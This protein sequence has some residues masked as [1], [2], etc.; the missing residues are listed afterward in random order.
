MAKEQCDVVVVGA[1]LA[2]LV[3][4]KELL[5]AGRSVQLLEASGDVGGRVR[6]DQVDGFSLDRGFQVLLTAYP[7]LGRQLDL[8]ALDLRNFDPG[9][10]LW[11]NHKL[12]RVGDP[13]RQPS[14]ALSSAIA[15]VGTVPDKLRLARL[16]LRLKRADPKLLLRGEEMTTMQA[17]Q[18][19][20]FS[21]KIIDRFFRPLVGG[22]QLDADLTASRRMFDVVLHC[23]AVGSS[24]VPATGMAAIP[25]QLAAQLPADVLRLNTLVTQVRPG[26]V[27]TSDGQIIAADSVV[28][29]TEGPSAASL[30]GLPPVKSRPVSCVWFTADQPP[31]TRPLI[32]LDSCRS[33]PTLNLAVMTNV[34]PEYSPDD[35]A[36]IAAACPHLGGRPVHQADQVELVQAVRSQMHGWFGTQVKAWTHLKTNVISHAQPDSGPPFSPK[37]KVA[38]GDGLFVCGDHRDTPSIQGAMFS[39]RRVAESILGYSAP[40]NDLTNY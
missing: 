31:F 19:E 7:E 2:G 18:V 22:I 21:P 30:L 23:L 5:R 8:E 26:Q 12:Q 13:L 37:R 33:G 24:A 20:G 32:A 4:A 16:L 14:A 10:L 11:M 38:L 3:A 40:S 6:T 29:A 17:L 28:I 9:A 27:T 25:Q 39:G 35:R 34:A 15:A 1:G 36:L